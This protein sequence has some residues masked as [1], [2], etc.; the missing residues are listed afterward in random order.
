MNNQTNYCNTLVL[1]SSFFKEYILLG[2]LLH[3]K[4]KINLN[5]FD[6]YVSSSTSSIIILLLSIGTSVTDIIYFFYTSDFLVNMSNLIK[7]GYECNYDSLNIKAKLIDFVEKEI[8]IVPTM[9]Q[10]YLM[11]GKNLSF[12]CEKDGEIIE[13][14]HKNY[15]NLLCTEAIILSLTVPF[16]YEQPQFLT[17]YKGF[18]DCSHRL[19]LPIKNIENSEFT[20][21]IHLEFS[22]EKSENICEDLLKN[23]INSKIERVISKFGQKNYKYCSTIYRNSHPY[24]R[25]DNTTDLIKEDISNGYL[26]FRE[27]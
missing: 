21:S 8:S 25:E 24:S 12:M 4:D 14:S 15:P 2:G 9:E 13:I 5:E 6:N 18:C 16:V 10:L 11:T 26:T 3:I 19:P 17:M 22:Q 27:F 7:D 23:L 20:V 1:G